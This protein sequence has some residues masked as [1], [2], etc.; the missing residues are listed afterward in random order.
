MGDE[1]LYPFDKLDASKSRGREA[2]ELEGGT[3]YWEQIGSEESAARLK[4]S[5]P[6]PFYRGQ[7]GGMV[8][9][10]N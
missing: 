6:I 7:D 9:R 1:I 4:S 8:K 3:R 5:L 10:E 2:L